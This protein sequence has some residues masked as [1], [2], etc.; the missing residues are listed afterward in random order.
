MSREE[1]KYTEKFPHLDT[2]PPK[3]SSIMGLKPQ[4]VSDKHLWFLDSHLE[5]LQE[6]FPE[7]AKE[8]QSTREKIKLAMWLKVNV[9]WEAMQAA[10][11]KNYKR[12]YRRVA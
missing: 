10:N 2:M 1:F 4:D 9:A 7:I 6:Q 3:I 11:N 5:W 8:I 12:K